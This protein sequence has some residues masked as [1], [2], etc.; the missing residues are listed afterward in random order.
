MS[1][2]IQ[3]EH[4][5]FYR[6]VP[7]S[8]ILRPALNVRIF[9]SGGQVDLIAVLDSGAEY[10]L[11]NGTRAASL[12]IDLVAGQQ[13]AMS[14]LGGT[15]PAYLH[16]IEVEIGG[17]RLRIQAAFSERH[18]SRELLGRHTLFDQTIWGIR[19]YRQEIYFSADPNRATT[20]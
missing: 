2:E 16:A 8:P 14:S 1:Q 4:T 20:P 19:E 12:G 13:I 15:F 5:F 3:F 18:I 9:A 17:I 10:C 11:F 7:P 6:E